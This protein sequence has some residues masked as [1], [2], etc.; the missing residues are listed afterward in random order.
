MHQRERRLDPLVAQV[1][2]IGAE[3]VGEEHALVDECARRQRHR[4]IVV[5]RHVDELEPAVRDDLAR[6]EEAALE[7]VLVG[8]A[9]GP[10][11]ED[12]QVNRFALRRR[13]RQAR[14]VDRHLAE[15]EQ[16]QAF[17][18][19]NGA[20]HVL[21]GGAA[22]GLAR[23][24]EVADAVM[25]GLRQFK[26]Q[27]RAFLAQEAMRDLHRHAGAVAGD[28]VR[29]HCAAMGEVQQHLQT[30]LDDLVRRLALHVRDEADAARVELA[31][32]IEEPSGSLRRASSRCAFH[33]HLLVS[34]C[35]P[36]RVPSVAPARPP[37]QGHGGETCFRLR[38]AKAALPR[39]PPLSTFRIAGSVQNG[40]ASLT[41]PEGKMPDLSCGR[42]ASCAALLLRRNTLRQ[43][44][45][46]GA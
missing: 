25:A 37:C 19:K 33:G 30:V 11:D 5:G 9:V 1:R 21:H 22:L 26:A 7:R 43:I 14:I 15:A 32:G 10:A 12:L 8:G 40:S 38:E 29:A 4:V 41:Y 36:A 34:S 17:F 31:A 2:I 35:R 44:R 13:F 24:E 20:P 18:L 16:G 6:D 28:R 45:K 27:L 39:V 3:L 42:K 46:D 23:H